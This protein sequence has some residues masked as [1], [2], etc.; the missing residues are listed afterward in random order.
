MNKKTR[1]LKASIAAVTLAA[2]SLVVAAPIASAGTGACPLG[3]SCVWIHYNYD[4]IAGE[5]YSHSSPVHASRDNNTKSAAANGKSCYATHFYDYRW[6]NSGSYFTLYSKYMKGSNY[7]DPNLSNG[8][9][10]GPYANEN[11]ADRIS[12]VTYDGC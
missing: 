5:N 1:S 3:A 10:V 2:T 9:G 11:W 4:G 7:Q 8:A 6:G 12:R